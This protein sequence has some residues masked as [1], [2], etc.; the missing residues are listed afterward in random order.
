MNVGDLIKWTDYKGEKPIAHIGIFIRKYVKFHVD[1]TNGDW[2]DIL[3]LCNGEYVRWTSWQC[4]IF[5][6]EEQ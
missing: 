3:V 1:A 4:E 2:A 6:G 5:N